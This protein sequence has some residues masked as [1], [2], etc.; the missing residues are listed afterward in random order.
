MLFQR[1]VVGLYSHLVA[2]QVVVELLAAEQYRVQFFLYLCV[3]LLSLVEAFD[4][5]ATGLSSWN[6]AAPRPCL[7]A[8]TCR[9]IGLA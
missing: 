8:S 7:L 6:R 9:V 3:V 2:I 4:A 1:L 5:K